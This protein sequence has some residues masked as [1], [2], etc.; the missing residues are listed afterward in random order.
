[1]TPKYLND[2]ARR[3]VKSEAKAGKVKAKYVGWKLAIQNDTDKPA[4]LAIGQRDDGYIFSIR[5]AI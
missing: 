2:T 5:V 1:M 3:A 4:L